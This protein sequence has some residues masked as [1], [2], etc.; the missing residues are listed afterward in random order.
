MEAGTPLSD[1]ILQILGKKEASPKIV[2]PKIHEDLI[3]RW[4]YIMINGLSD[5]QRKTL[6]FKLPPPENFENLTSPQINAVLEKAISQS[7]LARDKKLSNCQALVAGSLSAI[8]QVLSSILTKEG[9]GGDRQHIELLNDAGR[10]LTDLW[11]SQ[12]VTRRELIAINL[13]NE[14]QE[15]N[16]EIPL[17]NSLFGQDL[18]ERLKATKNLED[19]G[20][21]LKAKVPKANGK[22]LSRQPAASSRT[23]NSRAPTRYP[24]GTFRS[25]S[26]YY[27]QVPPQYKFKQQPRQQQK[28]NF[29]RQQ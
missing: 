17:D 12:T 6:L 27:Q 18:Q 7:N 16:K 19:C 22:N 5:E 20:K 9:E 10:M 25:R 24:R 1:D 26:Q 3:P 29:R 8:G 21:T 14:F 28:K 23:L 2:G 11:H 13:T 15:A 4:K